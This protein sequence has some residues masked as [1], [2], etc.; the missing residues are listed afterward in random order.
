[1]VYQKQTWYDGP[2]GNTPISAARLQHMEDGIGAIQ[3]GLLSGTG[4]PEGSV[5]APVGTRYIDTAA[6][7]GAVEWIK[8]SGSGNTGWKVVYGDTGWRDLTGTAINGWTGTLKARRVGGLS[9]LW[10]DGLLPTASTSDTVLD[11][12][13]LVGFRFPTSTARGLFHSAAAPPAI[14]RVYCDGSSLVVGRAAGDAM[15]LYGVI[16][17]VGVDVTP[18][19]P[20]TLPGTA[21]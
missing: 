9:M 18:P 1:V 7:N 3:G 14:R 21:A 13:T 16:E 4:F 19:W 11:V 6:T 12:S 15:S 5:T 2:T 10:A 8:A 20:T 17:G